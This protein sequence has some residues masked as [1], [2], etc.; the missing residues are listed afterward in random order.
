VHYRP[1]ESRG[2]AVPGTLDFFLVQ[3]YLL[4][5]QRGPSLCTVQ[6]HHQ[7]YPLQQVRVLELAQILVQVDG[8][9]P[10]I[11]LTR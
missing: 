10:T 3:R 5:L 4:H 7:P 8:L 6:V 9:P 11:R 2:A 1:T